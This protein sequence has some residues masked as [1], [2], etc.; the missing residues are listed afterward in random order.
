MWPFFLNCF[1]IGDFCSWTFLIIFSRLLILFS[2]KHSVVLADWLP[3]PICFCLSA[4]LFWKAPEALRKLEEERVAHI[5][6]RS[7]IH[8]LFTAICVHV[9]W[10]WE[11][12]FYVS[13]LLGVGQSWGGSAGGASGVSH[14]GWSWSGNRASGVQQQAVRRQA[15]RDLCLQP[16]LWRGRAAH[17]LWLVTYPW[18]VSWGCSLASTCSWA[19]GGTAGSWYFSSGC[20]PGAILVSVEL[21]RGSNQLQLGTPTLSLRAAGVCSWTANAQGDVFFPHERRVGQGVLCFLWLSGDRPH[22]L[23]KA[24]FFLLFQVPFLSSCSFVSWNEWVSCCWGFGFFLINMCFFSFQRGWF[25]E[26]NASNLK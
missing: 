7:W 5:N 1:Q 3:S 10:S 19:C 22:W 2:L 15:G 17:C 18:G 9:N 21:G 12:D 26:G 13:H 20:Q 24:D 6:V 8:V 16:C 4:R 14:N 25:S 11:D 23:F